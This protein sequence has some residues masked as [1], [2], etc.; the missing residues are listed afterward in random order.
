MKRE[1]RDLCGTLNQSAVIQS[2]N[3]F[4]RGRKLVV[5]DVESSLIQESSVEEFLKGIQER[6]NSGEGA[7][8]ISD[9][10]EDRMQVLVENVRIPRGMPRAQLEQFSENLQLN[11]G[12][13]ELVGILKS[14]GFKIAL[15]SSDFGFLM[16]RIFEQAGVDHAFSNSFKAEGR[17][18]HTG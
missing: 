16:K 17:G 6:V 7:G 15:L 2:E 9:A 10:G 18:I 4:N 12:A 11:P 14:M 1:L 8:E 3:I 5:F 13:L